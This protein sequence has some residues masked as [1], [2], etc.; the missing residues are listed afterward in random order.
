M[1]DG[2]AE[3]ERAIRDAW[4]AGDLPEAVEWSKRFVSV[5]GEGEVRVRPVFGPE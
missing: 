1:T 4:T 5:L 3:A 2:R